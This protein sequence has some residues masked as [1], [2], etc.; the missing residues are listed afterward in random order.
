MFVGCRWFLCF[1]RKRVEKWV[2]GGLAVAVGAGG[3]V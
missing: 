3:L 2:K 1:V